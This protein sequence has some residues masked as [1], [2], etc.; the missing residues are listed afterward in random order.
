[1]RWHGAS[2]LYCLQVLILRLLPNTTALFAALLS[3]ADAA[4]KSPTV[5]F[6][7][8]RIVPVIVPV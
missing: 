8:A 7:T 5:K 1:L 3:C 2:N 6:L 4:K